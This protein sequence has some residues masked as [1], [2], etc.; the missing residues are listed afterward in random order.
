MSELLLRDNGRTARKPHTCTFCGFVIAAGA[1][2]YRIFYNGRNC[3]ACAHCAER[4]E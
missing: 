4:T 3:K 1:T 2:I